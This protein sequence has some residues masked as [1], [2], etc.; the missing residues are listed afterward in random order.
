MDVIAECSHA[1]T[2][3]CDFGRKNDKQFSIQIQVVQKILRGDHSRFPADEVLAFNQ[4]TAAENRDR[5]DK[6]KPF[7]NEPITVDIGKQKLNIVQ[8]LVYDGEDLLLK[9]SLAGEY[10]SDIRVV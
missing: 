1:A 10:E 7:M 3:E 6:I 8:S 5:E 9:L 2:S 4:K